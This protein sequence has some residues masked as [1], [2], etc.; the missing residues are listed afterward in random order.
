MSLHALLLTR[1]SAQDPAFPKAVKKRWTEL[2]AW[3]FSDESIS[4]F[5]E[6]TRGR[7]KDGALRNYKR[8]GSQQQIIQASCNLCMTCGKLEADSIAH[9]SQ[10]ILYIC[11]HKQFCSIGGGDH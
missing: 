11:T 7:I 8:C 4:G 10:R 5:I 6:E 1:V 2:R 9:H 3:A